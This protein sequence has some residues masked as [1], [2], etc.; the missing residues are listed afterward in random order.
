MLLVIQLPSLPVPPP[1]LVPPRAPSPVI[2]I[3]DIL[4]LEGVVIR[5]YVPPPIVIIHHVSPA[6][7]LRPPCLVVRHGVSGVV[8]GPPLDV[9]IQDV[10]EVLP[11]F[12]LKS[13][14]T[15][16]FDL[17]DDVGSFLV[18][19]KGFEIM[20]CR[21]TSDPMGGKLQ[22]AG[23]E[24]GRGRNEGLAAWQDHGVCGDGRVIVESDGVSLDNGGRVVRSDTRDNE[25]LGEGHSCACVV[26]EYI[27]VAIEVTG[28]LGVE[29]RRAVG[30][31]VGCVDG[32]D[33][34]VVVGRANCAVRRVDGARAQMDVV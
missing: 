30:V 31:A 16:F 22:S 25:G 2:V 15:C 21:K 24:A 34:V 11:S 8:S 27:S 7:P 26:D 33:L 13:S 12:V 1:V 18:L 32:V 29:G 20:N 19:L 4:S 9:I 6:I 10:S 5:V 23:E 14:D 3:R 28:D 17:S